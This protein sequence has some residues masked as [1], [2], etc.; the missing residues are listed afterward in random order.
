MMEIQLHTIQTITAHHAVDGESN[1]Y[2]SPRR[3]KVNGVATLERR[4]LTETLPVEEA[5]ENQDV[6]TSDLAS[7][8]L[9]QL[10]EAQEERTPEAVA[11]EYEGARLAYRELNRRANQLARYLRARGVGP[12]VLVGICVSRSLDMV[13][14]LLGILKAGGAYLPLDPSYPKER[15]A[16]MIEDAQAPVLLTQEPLLTSLP[17][18]CGQ[19]IKLDTDWAEIAKECDE[20]LVNLCTLDNLAY[21]IYTS[22]STG[23][24]KGAQLLQRG[25]VNVLVSMRAWPGISADDILLAIT[26]LSFDIASLELL[27]PLLVGARVL[28]AS[29]D[30][31]IDPAAL[32]KKLAE[33]GA[34]ILQGTPAT[35]RLLVQ[36][37]W[38]GGALKKAFSGG[39]ALSRQLANQLLDRGVALFNLYGPTETTIYSTGHQVT[40][41]EGPV[42]IG[43][44]VANTEAY[45]LDENLHSVPPG[46]SGELHLGGAGLAWGYLNRPEQTAA[47]FIA[48]PFS[49]EPGARLYKTGDLVRLMP[50]GHIEYL[51]RIDHQVKIRGYR[52]EP[53]EIEAALTRYPGV[54]EAVV[55]AREDV[56]GDKRLVGYLVT[57]SRAS[58]SATALRGFLKEKLPEYM[59]PATFVVLGAFPLTANGKVDR[60]ALPAPN[61]ERPEL[62]ATL[63]PPRD[64][65]ESRLG[66]LFESVLGVRHV[67]VKDNFFELGGDSLLAAQL[68]AQIREK[69]GHHLPLAVL[70]QEATVEHLA[71]LLNTQTEQR[72]W[73]SL[74]PL[75]QQG[76]K[77]PVFFVH[78]IGGDVLTQTLLARHLGLNQPFYGLRAQGMD[79]IREPLVR[80]EDM[81]AHY[82]QEM[83]ALQPKGP[84]FLGGYSFGGIVAFEMAWQLHA[85]GERVGFLAIID[86]ELVDAYR[87]VV[88]QPTWVL[89]FFHNL[90]GWVLKDCREWP[91][92]QRWAHLRARVADIKDQLNA[93]L[94]FPN[95]GPREWNVQQLPPDMSNV[96]PIHRQVWQA[97]HKALMSYK[98]QTYPGRIIVFRARTR[99]LISTFEPKLGWERYAT[100]GVQ[101]VTIPGFHND[102]I[103][104]PHVHALAAAVRKA[105]NRSTREM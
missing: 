70:A 76:T 67:G 66:K 65:C 51:G 101:V 89:R 36:A 54:R 61:N 50:H 77:R 86:Q 62:T 102:I 39:E 97:N 21:V 55:V 24:P 35:W 27:L 98:P 71:G 26:T 48:H 105:L 34:T 64:E 6:R 103:K 9:H 74:V 31:V 41:R 4:T 32:A 96:P 38:Q 1:V 23:K 29:R 18:R 91:R 82:L 93:M 8:C 95:G 16:F 79:G 94:R 60:R 3:A 56:P 10:I 73:P 45:V 20:N 46:E 40:T 81:A 25:L 33:S 15:L 88:W 19:I 5:V 57:D 58:F 14:G 49:S 2:T 22:G 11:V 104:E 100:G 87:R 47:R 12:D 53:G 52:I 28:I 75:Q 84:Y 85:I 78:G 63:V 69:F 17:E 83:R 37:G 90:P 42:F 13:V 99:P 72:P 80:V 68:M 43:R 7:P 92:G 30:T 44:P 59:V